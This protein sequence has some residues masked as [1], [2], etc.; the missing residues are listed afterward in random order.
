MPRS[1]SILAVYYPERGK[2]AAA[3]NATNKLENI[4]VTKPQGFALCLQIYEWFAAKPDF[5]G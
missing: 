4:F 1:R 3:T 5:R 2:D